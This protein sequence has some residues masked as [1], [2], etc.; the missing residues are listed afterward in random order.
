MEY[1]LELR[2]LV[3]HRPL[4]MVGTATLIVDAANRLLMMKRSDNGSWGLP[5]GG[6][7]LG[8]ELKTAASRELR[9]ETG[10]E[11]DRLNLF[12]IFSGREFFYRYPNGDE[13]YGIMIVYLAQAWHGE[14]CLN[15]E[16]TEWDWFA[17]ADIP[18]DLNPLI[19][20]IIEKY[21]RGDL[22]P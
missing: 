2:K 4:L 19:I 8:E 17:A 7:E 1:I 3:G 21:I 14:V 13:V 10:L 18:A 12:G 16:H 22:T 9:E 5:G 6:V 20:P 11:G 15:D